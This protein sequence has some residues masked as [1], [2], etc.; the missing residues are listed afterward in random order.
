MLLSLNVIKFKKSQLSLCVRVRV[1]IWRRCGAE[2]LEKIKIK[3]TNLKSNKIQI[4]MPIL[5]R[6]KK[7]KEMKKIKKNYNNMCVV[8][9]I[10][11]ANLLKSNS[12]VLL[13]DV[14]CVR[15]HQQCTH[16]RIY[17]Y[18]YINVYKK[19]LS[20]YICIIFLTKLIFVFKKT[21]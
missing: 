20:V 7:K 16:T 2:R 13:Y 17:I 14:M 21:K 5:P 10:F 12:R 18:V 6:V 11:D 4:F 3:Q 1:R 15:V 19:L 8:R 9:H